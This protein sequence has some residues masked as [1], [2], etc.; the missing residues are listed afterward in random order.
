[1]SKSRTGDHF[2]SLFEY[3]PISLWEE[4]YSGIKLFY[5]NLR[6]EGVTD[7]NHYLDQHPEE[8]EKN[9]R[10][11][12]VTHV[13]RE[14]LNMFDASSEAELL[15]N[16]DKIF[17]DE[18]RAHFRSELMALWN[19]ELSWSGDG[20]NYRLSGEALY[21]HLHWRILPECESNW[22][23]VL[24]SI[25]DITALKQTEKRFHDLFE[26]API[27]LWEED[28]AE[29]KKEFDALRAQGV[30]DLRAHLASHPEAVRHFMSLIRVLDV[31]QRTLAL[32]EAKD[33]Q[34]LLG[35]LDKVFRGEMSTH[36]VDELLDMWNGKTHYEREGINYS[37]SGEPI[38]VHLHWTLMPEHENDFNWVLIALQDVTARKKVE[39][40]LR[41]LGTHDVMTG[42][43]NRAYFEETLQRIEANRQDPISFII[44]DLN[45]L[46]ETN[47]YL[48]HQAGDGLIRRT[49]EVLKASLEAD[50]IAARIGGDE[51]VIIMPDSAA[52]VA[53]LVTEHLQ[54]LVK[55]NN[56][57]YRDPELSISLGAA[58]S[59]SGLSLEKV[60][61]LA[62][63]A[64]YRNKGQFH[65]RRKGD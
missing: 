55:M 62:D 18:M 33:K 36:F 21:I 7:L 56:K 4:D 35:N 61:S 13:N 28:Y 19:G 48:G 5:D 11:M 57:Y 29:L 2:E 54:S 24:V 3:A 12:K 9:M 64:M 65:R 32:F 34:T 45:G 26:Y 40:Y 50:H 44:V 41:Y 53:A 63:D 39:E 17:R 42:L 49:G 6:A 14:T 31:N 47:D 37:L 22:E 52:E 1:M 15:A 60:I 58:T 38:N 23:R 43:Y 46:K 27:S 51:F 30:M 8:I 20:I 25:E 16:L 59:E 10:R